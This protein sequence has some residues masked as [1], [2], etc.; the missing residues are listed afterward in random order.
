MTTI[1]V[2][3]RTFQKYAFIVNALEN[4]W[5]VKKKRGT[6]IF[7]KKHEGKKEIL[8]D[9]YLESFISDNIKC[10]IMKL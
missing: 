4:G 2:N 3:E 10:S 5:K 7:T 9:G 8:K 6:Y 1:S